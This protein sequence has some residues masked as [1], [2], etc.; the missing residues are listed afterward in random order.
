MKLRDEKKQLVISPPFSLLLFLPYCHLLSP[1]S[2]GFI[3][4]FFFSIFL[5]IH[6]F[7]QVSEKHSQFS[8]TQL[9]PSPCLSD[10]MVASFNCFFTDYGQGQ[11]VYTFTHLSRSPTSFFILFLFFTSGFLFYF[12]KLRWWAFVNWI[13]ELL[14]CLLF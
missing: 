13:W 7:F 9:S 6:H 12:S 5:K 14:C 4:H 11:G 2:L 8:S 1:F 10:S 3:L